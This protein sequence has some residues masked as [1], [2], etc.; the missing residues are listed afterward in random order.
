[1]QGHREGP[2]RRCV[3]RQGTP[4]I[5]FFSGQAKPTIK[6]TSSPFLFFARSFRSELFFFLAPLA[7]PLSKTCRNSSPP[8][9][10]PTRAPR[11]SPPLSTP[12][13][14]PRP[15]TRTLLATCNAASTLSSVP[16]RH[17]WEAPG[18]DLLLLC[19]RPGAASVI[20]DHPNA[21]C[22]VKV[23]SSPPSTLLQQ[24][25]RWFGVWCRMSDRPT[26]QTLCEEAG[27]GGS[28]GS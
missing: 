24:C 14:C 13:E 17:D 18:F 9:P 21:G 10:T 15:F 3:Q 7:R 27:R 16:A 20:H 22:W 2:L 11:H 23:R 8:P 5:F 26:G 28:R 12:E 6:S 25:P 1:M 4:R 19:W